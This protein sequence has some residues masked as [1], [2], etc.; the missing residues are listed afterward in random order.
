MS[1]LRRILGAALLLTVYVPLHRLLD[2]ARTGP[3]GVATRTA[4]EAAWTLGVS[5]TL[6]VLTF[7]WVCVRMV[8]AGR[9]P[10]AWGESAVRWVGTPPAPTFA[11]CLGFL[12]TA[13]AGLV[14][15]TVHG[16]APTTVDEMAQLLHA[17]AI[18]SGRMTI[19]LQGPAAA[20][21]IQNGIAVDGGWASIYPPVHTLLLAG[22]LKSGLAWLVGPIA[23][24]VATAAT[25][26]AGERLLGVAT[27]RFAG[28]LLVVSPFW[29]LLGST[30]L[31]HATAAAGLA[32][33][34]WTGVRATDGGLIWA[35]AAGAAV[36]FAV[37][38]RP[39]VGLVCATAIL[40][41]LW[42]PKRS[43]GGTPGPVAL[44][45]G[46]ALLVG[47]APFAGLL[48]WWNSRLFGDPLRLGYSAAFGPSHG[49]GLRVDPWGNF[50]GAVEAVA[51]TGSDLAALALRMFESP[52]PSLAVVG[53]VLL[54]RPLPRG[55]AVFAAW[56]A[57]AVVA[58]AAYWHHGIHMGPR[59]LF[60]GVPAWVALFAASGAV[61]FR[62]GS[63]R[64]A[65]WSLG[66][67]LIASW[68]LSLGAARLAHVPTTFAELPD[69]PS[70]SAI[71]FVHGTW[72][73]RIAARLAATNMRRDSIETALRRNDVCA[74]D[75]Y[76]RWRSGEVRVGPEP[77]LDFEALPGSPARL[78]TRA[79]SPGNLVRV[80]PGAPVSTTC[81]REARADRLGVMELELL[82]WR[83][84]PLP[85]ESVVF[86]RDLGPAGNLATLDA[87]DRPAFMYLDR[88][89]EAE[90]VLLSYAEGMELLWGG[91]AGE[92]STPIR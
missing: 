89:P 54:V 9:I 31:S 11:I 70:E 74:V 18:A 37:A 40:V 23:I 84:P 45:R 50:Y 8:P 83:A 43:G 86:A 41:T 4:A 30:H 6:I 76:A 22:G 3:A 5:G 39:W 29:L 12:A 81:M 69:P 52:I 1:Y 53:A 26:S 77:H 42:W 49:L 16:G 59:M 32:L 33:V 25:V 10:R 55:V 38:T 48:F 51:Y 13:L 20:W 34:V 65:G 21:M 44:R 62:P 75:R 58:D 68:P 24:G 82:A 78:E 17:S 71:V 36:G 67:A 19:P 35:V 92:A 90:P 88:T 64:L 79:L 72:S 7:A 60:E 56:A 87:V 15:V 63:S 57:A 61:V 28:L 27:A 47:G 66:I 46:I 80:E 91:A 2:P 85:S 14:A 73:S